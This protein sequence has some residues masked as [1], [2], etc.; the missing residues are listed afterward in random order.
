MLRA[1]YRA[2]TVLAVPALRLMLARRVPRGK[3]WPDRLGERRGIDATPR[4]SGRL[5]WLH[6][7]SVGP[8][9]CFPCS[10]P[11]PGSR[12]RSRC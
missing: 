1:L 4:P 7:A 10:R 8:S 5:L 12:P 2:G 6:A 3:E 11:S 9:R